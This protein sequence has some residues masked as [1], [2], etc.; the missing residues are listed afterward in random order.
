MIKKV[1]NTRN[2]FLLPILLVILISIDH[3]VLFFNLTNNEFWAKYLSIAIEVFA[4]SSII[5]I[6]TLKNVKWSVYGLFVIVVIVQF[7]GNIF[8]SYYRIDEN[9]DLFHSLKEFINTLYSQENFETETEFEKFVKVSLAFFAGG[10][11]P[12]L[13]L[14]SL[15]FYSKSL[16]EEFELD[17]SVLNDSNKLSKENVQQ[18]ENNAIELE[19]E[20]TKPKIE[21][22]LEIIPNYDFVKDENT[23]LLEKPKYEFTTKIKEPKKENKKEEFKKEEQTPQTKDSIII[24]K[25]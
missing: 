11:I 21:P 22:L 5:A 9:S 7:L 14:F 18:K 23:E 15:N 24:T 8:Y 19:S 13:S 20:P 3:L 16:K 1:F 4:M 12:L 17:K 2:L 10:I 25:R 6:S